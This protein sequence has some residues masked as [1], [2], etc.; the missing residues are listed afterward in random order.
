[1]KSPPDTFMP[2]NKST[3]NISG[4]FEAFGY[5]LCI[6]SILRLTTVSTRQMNQN[7]AEL[8]VDHS[9]K[10]VKKVNNCK[11]LFNQLVLFVRSKYFPLAHNKA[12]NR[13][14]RLGNKGDFSLC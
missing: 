11:V 6:D 10:Q 3:Y 9:I 8:L 5:R 7:I 12:Q 14:V 4:N 1:M 2:Y 13:L